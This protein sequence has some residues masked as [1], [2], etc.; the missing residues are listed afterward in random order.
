MLFFCCE[1][2][3]KTW[4]R[5][6]PL[7]ILEG[8]EGFGLSYAD[9][10]NLHPVKHV[11]QPPWCQSLFV[12]FGK[13]ITLSLE[14]FHTGNFKYLSI[15][16]WTFFMIVFIEHLKT[17]ILCLSSIH[18]YFLGGSLQNIISQNNFFLRHCYFVCFIWEHTV[19][20][21]WYCYGKNKVLFIGFGS[22][23]W[24]ECNTG[25]AWFSAWYTECMDA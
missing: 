7:V 10:S 25:S 18:S 24:L 9:P 8:W 3:Q 15:F 22:S 20:G 4:V 23:C 13:F 1:K 21:M 5:V 17:I 12:F 19:L 6:T 14:N 11:C 2:Y 16:P